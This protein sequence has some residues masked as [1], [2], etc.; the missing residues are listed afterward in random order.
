[1]LESMRNQAQTWIA[2]LILGGVALSFVLWGI[3]DYFNS[4]GI[5]T[6]AEVDGTPI[7]DVDFTLAYERQMA[8]Y[9]SLLG[10]QFSKQAVEALGLKE[11][12]IQ[13]LI[14]R[15][16]ILSEAE[17]MGVVAPQD[18]LL[19]SVRANPSFQ[20]SGSFDAQRYQVLTRNLGY[21]TPTDYEASLR[22][23][24][25]ADALQKGLVESATVTDAAVRDSFAREFEQREVAAVIV[26]PSA[27][28]N[29]VKIDDGQAR[30]WY[31]SHKDAY[32]SPL[33]LTLNVVSIDP[34]RLA[35]DIA[36]SEDDIK[37][38]YE[39]H[40][41]RYVQ[42]ETRHARHILFALP[43]NADEAARAAAMARA[44]KAL[45]AIESGKSF[46]SVAKKLSEDAAT[47]RNG[48]DIGYLPQGATVSTFDAALFAMHKGE[49][50]DVVETPFGLHLIELEDIKPEHVKTLAEVHDALKKELALSLA[51]EE[52]YKLSQELDDALGRED[53]LKAAADSIN[54][55][56]IQY[57][58]ISIEEA[59]AYP[60]LGNA[61]YRTQLFTR[62]PGDPI[63]VSELDKGQFVA[64]EI[65]R[66]DEPA[67]QPFE[68][69]STE[70]YAD[71]QRAAAI[72]QARKLTDDI[73]AEAA[74][75]SLDKLAQKHAMPIYLS[76]P[77]RSNGTGDKDADWL[78]PEVLQAA[79]SL[80]QG[81]VAPQ[82]MQVARGFAVIQTRQVIAANAADFEKQQDAIRSAL[83]RSEG[84]VRFARWMAHTRASHDIRIHQS[85]LGKL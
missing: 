26:E 55:K 70:V 10:K 11:E 35:D 57:G 43:K 82:V 23:D 28:Q 2:K 36:V 81:E 75:A 80:K 17:R 60:V 31:E 9:R 45:K 41:D 78:T 14:N 68:K 27:M 84:A 63:E 3:G 7:S 83:L 30:A 1:M 15:R 24:L 54:L 46:A 62:H 85:V 67:A 59:R 20:S 69:V 74:S 21:R 22:L 44:D 58:P 13:T 50:S 52:G 42:A 19:A 56:A 29:K 51:D 61:G 77:V 16:L 4:A 39:Q 37:A 65:L 79:F 71:A 18:V 33:R 49:I 34:K 66:R 73:L 53:S 6:V 76:R 47:A 32:F 25:I 40:K 72:E 12:T 38:A 8:N 64:I 5:Q 48:G